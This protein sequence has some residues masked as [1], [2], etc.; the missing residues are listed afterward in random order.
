[1]GTDNCSK[2]GAEVG[3]DFMR[4]YL[5][6]QL[7]DVENLETLVLLTRDKEGAL[8][9]SYNGTV[10]NLFTLK[11]KF[12]LDFIDILFS[13]KFHVNDNYAGEVAEDT[14]ITDYVYINRRIKALVKELK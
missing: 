7:K 2:I 14:P 8:A 4:E 12:D 1:M 3:V 13:Y 5:E 9:L 10:A 6:D 11:S